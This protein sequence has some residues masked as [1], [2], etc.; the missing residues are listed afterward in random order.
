MISKEQIRGARAMLGLSPEDL[1]GASGLSTNEVLAAERGETAG[2]DLYRLRLALEG[3]GIVFLG[4]GEDD[5][6]AGPGL[7][8]RQPPMDEG[9]RP[10]NL[11]SAN[12]G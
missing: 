1:A 9:I 5:A 8:L 10:E 12:D 6:G 11:S 7:R 4:A 3:R 2:I